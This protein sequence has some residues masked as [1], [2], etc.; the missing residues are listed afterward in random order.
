M[1]YTDS[2]E[3]EKKR[4]L[5][6]LKIARRMLAITDERQRHLLDAM[7]AAEGH[8]DM[9]AWARD[10]VRCG[11]TVG[12]WMEDYVLRSWNDI[13]VAQRIVV[14]ASPDD[15]SPWGEAWSEDPKSWTKERFRKDV[16]VWAKSGDD[17]DQ[18][19]VDIIALGEAALRYDGREA[20][21]LGLVV[22]KRWDRRL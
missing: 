12:E 5:D 11:R 7:A 13:E 9:W 22:K 2:Y 10:I 8:E 14:Y 18:D 3:A 21:R 4:S 17:Q 16:A 20:R 6:D 15:S 1:S 19:P